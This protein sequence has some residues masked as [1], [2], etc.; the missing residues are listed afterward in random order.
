MAHSRPRILW[1]VSMTLPA[2]AAACGLASGSDVS[3]GWLAGQL[4][5]L[6]PTADLTVCSLD[7]RVSAQT[8]GSAGGVRYLLLPAT[9][10][11]ADFTDLL[12]AGQPELVHI[13]GTEYTAALAMLNAANA[14]SLPALVGIQGVMRDCAAHLCDGVPAQYLRSCALQRLIDRVVPGAL[15]DK[16]QQRFDA[17][18]RSEAALLAQARHVTGRTAFDMQA[19]AAL[20]P[21][22]RYYP[23][24]ETLRPL[25]YGGALWQGHDGRDQPVLLLTQ[26]NYP[27]KNLHTVLKA[28][29]ALLKRWPGL[30]L[31]VA[32]WPPLDKGPLLR[33]VIDWMFPY[34]TYCKRLIAGLGLAEHVRYTGPL[35]PDAMRQ[36][37]LDADLFILP[38]FSENSP[39]SLGE[40]MLLGM[41]CVAAAVGGIP[42]M[43]QDKTEA[44]LYAPAGDGAA[45]ACAVSALLSDPARA[46]ALGN[47]ARARALR[48]H[49]PAA[50]AAA[51]S[52]IYRGILG[53]SPAGKAADHEGE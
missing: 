3:G 38:S 7:C 2:A 28:M 48:T 17:L 8:A 47:A 4:D 41:P 44:L 12:R 43:A 53:A 10:G 30:L 26:G 14:L 39:N 52:G 49:D 31:R 29:P 51:L 9:A 50:N 32:G 15:L 22:A 6:R 23:C 16:S 34:Q 42:S 5:A 46:A 33:P 18:A 45:L 19:A 21:R 13:W 11:E 20:A 37:Y 36:A 35:G 40:A 25:F 1:L 27:L 24:N